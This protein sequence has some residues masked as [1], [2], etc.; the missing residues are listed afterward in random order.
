MYHAVVIPVSTLLYITTKHVCSKQL[1]EFQQVSNIQGNHPKKAE[2]NND[3]GVLD[4]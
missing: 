2:I 3:D 4:N 1:G